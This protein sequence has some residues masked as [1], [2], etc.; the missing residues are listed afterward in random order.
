MLCAGCPSSDSCSSLQVLFDLSCVL[1][2]EAL[3]LL[4]E[5][6]ISFID[7]VNICIIIV[8]TSPAVLLTL[9]NSARQASMFGDLW[10]GLCT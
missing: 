2:V 10:V 5:L 1:P 9:L 4:V 3:C 8:R 6:G 7:V